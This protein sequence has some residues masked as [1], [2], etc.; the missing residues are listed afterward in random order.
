MTYEYDGEGEKVH[1]KLAKRWIDNNLPADEDVM[2]ERYYFHNQYEVHYINGNIKDILYIGGDA[3][4]A[5][6]CYTRYPKERMYENEEDTEGIPWPWEGKIIVRDHQNSVRYVFT[7]DGQTCNQS[8]SY[9]AWGCMQTTNG[10]PASFAD[11]A[12]GRGFGSHEQWPEVGLIHMN[13]RL[14]DPVTGSF[15]SPDPEITDKENPQAYNR[16]AYCIGNP[17]KYWDPTG[18]RFWES[19]FNYV[20]SVLTRAEEMVTEVKNFIMGTKEESKAQSGKQAG[21]SKGD[22]DD[23]INLNKPI[24]LDQVTVS[25]T[26]ITNSKSVP[27]IAS[28]IHSLQ[29]R[30]SMSGGSQSTGGDSYYNNALNFK[31]APYLSGGYSK[32]GIDCSGLVNRATGNDNHNWTTKSEI[33]PPGNWS[34]INMNTS[35]YNSFISGAQ[36]GDLFLWPNHHTAFYA[37]GNSLFHAHGD[38]GTPTGYTNDL[39]TYWVEE[40]GYPTA[41]RQLNIRKD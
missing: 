30:T 1:S 2:A 25:A 8:V 29:G 4:T 34:K 17:I 24:H 37:G 20:E 22:D 11:L 39:R 35:S 31:D 32:N 28:T 3:Y 27:E 38:S 19:I 23:P 33:P 6:I 12:L 5:P 36:K 40:L 9:N 41:Y 18:R 21:A 15:L 10:S 13:A 7:L 16:Y 14:Y 26:R